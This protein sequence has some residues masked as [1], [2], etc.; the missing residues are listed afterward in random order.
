M[1]KT[2]AEREY[3]EEV[4]GLGVCVLCQELG[5]P[6]S[7]VTLH[8][9]RTGQGMGQRSS[10]WLVVPLCPSCHQGPTGVHGDQALL[11]IARVT[12]MDLLART[13]E[14]VARRRR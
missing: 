5:M 6:S 9:V 14:L 2:E 3:H 8:H 1:K 4:A 13:V 12:E 10:H 7:E 11:R